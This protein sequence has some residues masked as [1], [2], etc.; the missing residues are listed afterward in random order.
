MTTTYRIYREPRGTYSRETGI[1]KVQS[2]RT[3]ANG[4][5]YWAFVASFDTEKQARDF[6]YEALAGGGESIIEV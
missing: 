5:K 6:I 1:I 3:E 4:E 2:L